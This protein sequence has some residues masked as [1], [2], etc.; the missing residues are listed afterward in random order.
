M[1]RLSKQRH[2]VP[3]T[4]TITAEGLTQHFLDHVFKLHGLPDSIISDRGPRFA[5]RFWTYLCYCLGIEPRLS[6]A[7]HP[8]TDGQTKRISASMEE[9]LRGYVN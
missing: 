9:Y 3:C 5:S 8:Q 6:T 1:D 4:T 7:F 2:F